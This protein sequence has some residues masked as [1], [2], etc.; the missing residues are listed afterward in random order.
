MMRPLRFVGGALQLALN[1]WK[2]WRAERVLD[3]R[4]RRYP[5]DTVGRVV[6]YTAIH[7]GRDELRDARPFPGVDYVCFTDDKEL[8]SRTWKIVVAEGGPDD[9]RMR[10]KTSKILPHRYFPDHE[11]SLWVDGTHVPAV[12]P[13]YLCLKYLQ[14]HDIAL[15]R[16]PIRSC[17]YDEMDACLRQ[18]RG[19][20]EDIRR[21]RERY[22]HE[23]YPR[24]NGLATCTVILRRHHAGHV[25]EAME[26]WWQE[27]NRFSVRDQLSFNYVAHR[28]G[29]HYAAIPGH[30]YRNHYF[31]F[32]PHQR[33]DA[34]APAVGWILNGGRE[35]ASSRIMGDNVH[36]HLTARGLYSKLLF[37]PDARITSRL[38]LA[39]EQCDEMLR[40]NINILA[41]VKL[42][43]GHNLDYLLG[44]C[45][46]MG[47]KVV[48]AVCDRPSPRMLAAADAVIA[49][50][51]EFRT[52]IP[53]KH[54]HKLHVVFD[55]YEHDPALRKKHHDRRALTLC[56]VTNQVWDAVP[57]IPELPEGV[58]L[59]II[60]PGPEILAGSFRGSRVFRDSPFP[61]TYVPWSEETAVAE[62]LECDA[63]II[64]WPNVGAAERLK[65]ANRLVLFMSLGMPVIAS[66][67]PS[68]L[69]LVRTG[70]NGFIARR[71]DE[72]RDCIRLLR[73]DPSRRLALGEAARQDVVDRYSKEKQGELYLRIL[74]QV[75][76]GRT[77]APGEK[78][79]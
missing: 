69:P 68:Y 66:P 6:V 59:K 40:H 47:I 58:S 67:V 17:I 15:F 75:L 8:R 3:H 7:G 28:R 54:H 9:P 44:R 49:N 33:P 31:R 55:G 25:V 24:H 53:R 57:C 36:E 32:A 30:I 79:R 48:Y 23:G 18:N 29:L 11:Y 10:A 14:T 56:L 34:A 72:W 42:D 37:R 63:G 26:E 1:S 74:D 5:L 41:I 43:N 71:P 12:D 35:T 46:K 60:G 70:E 4:A 45:R 62:I 20:A 78:S 77:A 2:N 22:L 61:F 51:E 64:P 76:R 50:S 16:H 38:Q 65:S 39:R 27:I 21:Q 19:N 13:R 52:V 73:D